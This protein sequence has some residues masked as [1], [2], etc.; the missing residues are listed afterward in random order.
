MRIL[1]SAL[2]MH[3]ARPGWVYICVF[4]P[5]L[6][7]GCAQP[8][9][10]SSTNDIKT[11]LRTGRISLQVQSEPVQS[12]SASFELKGKP[13]QGELTLISPLGSVLGVLRW[14]PGEAMLDSGNGKI[15]RFSSVDELM[16]Q[17]TGAAVPVTALFAWL[18]GDNASV[19]GWSADLSRYAEGRITARRVQP[20]PPADLR[21]VLDQ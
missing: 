2:R 6:I 15:Q 20:A 5:F 18:R 3:L 8:Q 21:V 13:E 7:A 17:A 11:E 10:A 16:A 4:A 1:L 12:F 9:R 19:S 14:S